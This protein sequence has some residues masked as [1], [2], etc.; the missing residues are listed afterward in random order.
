MGAFIEV[1]TKDNHNGRKTIHYATTAR[2]TLADLTGMAHAVARI[3]GCPVEEIW[4]RPAG[5]GNWI[6]AESMGREKAQAS[7]GANR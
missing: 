2:A 1:K 6:M 5:R 7:E 4:F 3:A